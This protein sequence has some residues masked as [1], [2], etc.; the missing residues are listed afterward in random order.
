MANKTEPLSSKARRKQRNQ[1]RWAAAGVAT[2]G[3]VAGGMTAA[4][5]GVV[6]LTVSGTSVLIGAVSMVLAGAVFGLAIFSVVRSF[7][8]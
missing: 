1:E 7:L 8:R 6:D 4:A 3:G 5:V 2:V